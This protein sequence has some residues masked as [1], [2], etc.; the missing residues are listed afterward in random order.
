MQWGI[1]FDRD[2]DGDYVLSREGGHRNARILHSDGDA[3]GRE[4]MR[5]MEHRVREQESIRVFDRCFALDL[6]TLND[7][8]ERPD[9]AEPPR[10]LGAITFHPRY[11]L[12]IIWAAATILATG[13]AGRVY[14][15]TTNPIVATGDGLAMAYRAGAV[16]ADVEFMQ[17]H[18]TTLYVAGSTRSLISEAVRGE[19][20]HLVNRQGQRFMSDYHEMAELAPRDIVSRAIMEQLAHSGE[21]CV[22][23]DVRHLG[24]EAFRKR[25][26][27]LDEIIGTFD[28][29]P[30]EDLI[31]VHPSAHYTVGGV[32]TDLDG[33]TSLP[34]LYACG[35]AGCNGLH[36]ANRLASNSLLEGLVYGRRAGR[37]AAEMRG[38]SVAPT[39]IVSEVHYPEHGELD[40]H[41]VRS[42]LRSVMWR[43]VGI[44]RTGARL[45]DVIDMFDFW[46][47]YTLQ[48]IFD[49]PTGW[50]T[51]NLLTNGA[52][53]TR[54]ARWRQETRGVHTRTD[55]PT[56]D[57]RY[58]VHATWRR[59]SSEPVVKPVDALHAVT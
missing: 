25:F 9:G 36:G 35:E 28:I 44:E 39:K 2:D 51:Q 52:M 56:A 18:P 27:G 48:H 45:D 5:C 43:N 19:G 50:E 14:R 29:D 41:D 38:V 8:T 54:A 31:P 55:F 4:M 21:D 17:F 47:R 1:R 24:G 13:G 20:A 58:L 32:W 34:G 10:V 59:G 6:L 49:T 3:T 40:L 12:Q 15:E 23:L 7:S 11:G 33:R 22:Y 37:A 42:S 16:V 53:M 30:G 26:P 46:A 57:D